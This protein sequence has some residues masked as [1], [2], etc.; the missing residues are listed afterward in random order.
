[1]RFLTCQTQPDSPPCLAVW[2][3]SGWFQL[4]GCRDFGDWLRLTP[5]ERESVLADAQPI[6]PKV[7]LPPVLRPP[8]VRDFYAFETHVR[9]AHRRRGREVP[10]EWYQMP[11]FYFSNPASLIGHEQPVRK[12]PDTDQL[13]YE[14]ELAVIIRR[15]GGDWSLAEAESAIA[16]FTI[17]NDWSARDI[18]RVEMRIGL[19]PA[20]A[21]DFATSLG[22]WVVTPDELEP[23]RE[24]DPTRG[25]RWRLTMRAWVNGDLMSEGNAAEMYWSFAELI[26]HAS[27]NTRLQIGDVIGSGTVGTGCLLERPEGSHR[28]LQPG[29]IVELEIEGIGRLRN[30]VI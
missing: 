14:L 18:Q 21:K 15:E 19:G 9:N 25:S 8:S 4:K 24:S 17:M 23:W 28:W 22:P 3:E 10:A 13:D 20:K 27:R 11:A 5:V 1:M 2:R 29:D 30:R 16:G 6:S 12:P 7:Y 26:A